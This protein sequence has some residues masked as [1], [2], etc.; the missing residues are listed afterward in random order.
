MVAVNK[1]DM[2]G[3]SFERFRDI[4]YASINFLMSV[5]YKEHN[6]T[7]VPISGLKGYNLTSR[8]SQPKELQKWYCNDW[9]KQF[10]DEKQSA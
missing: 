6:I 1:L 3:W 2:V 8:D 7:F 10:R 5:G 4:Y 9:Y